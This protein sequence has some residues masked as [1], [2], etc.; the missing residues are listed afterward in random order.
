MTFGLNLKS[1]GRSIR[2][3]EVDRRSAIA[4][5]QFAVLNDAL[6]HVGELFLG[7]WLQDDGV[8]MRHV[9]IAVRLDVGG[10][11]DDRDVGESGILLHFGG[12]FGAV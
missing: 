12:E 7:K 1:R 2:S 9:E 10:L 8:E 4:L 11:R 6:D 3:S 5:L